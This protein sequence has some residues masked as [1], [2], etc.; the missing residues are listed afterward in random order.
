M[1]VSLCI[2]WHTIIEMKCFDL[3]RFYIW[4]LLSKKPTVSLWQFINNRIQPKFVFWTPLF[5]NN[6]KSEYDISTFTSLNE[7]RRVACLKNIPE[8]NHLPVGLYHLWSYFRHYN[9]IKS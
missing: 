1:R 6:R 3:F 2:L 5:F 8:G 9:I 4:T 7:N